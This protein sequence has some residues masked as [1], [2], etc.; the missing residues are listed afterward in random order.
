MFD[1]CRKYSKLLIPTLLGLLFTTFIMDDFT[2]EER[3][4]TGVLTEYSVEID[5]DETCE[6]DDFSEEPNL[7]LQIPEMEETLFIFL[8]AVEHSS[9]TQ[10]VKQFRELVRRYAPNHASTYMN[11]FHNGIDS[12]SGLCHFLF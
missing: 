7:K 11:I 6:E 10:S 3:K 2:N 1:L 8:P 12:F 4:A 5:A 9:C